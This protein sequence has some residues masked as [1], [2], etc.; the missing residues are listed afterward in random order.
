MKIFRHLLNDF[1]WTCDPSCCVP[2]SIPTRPRQWFREEIAYSVIPV[3]SHSRLQVTPLQSTPGQRVAHVVG[4][5]T[6]VQERFD[7]LLP[8]P[9]PS[10]AEKRNATPE[11]NCT[12]PHRSRSMPL[13]CFCLE[14]LSCITVAV[15]LLKLWPMSHETNFLPTCT[16][17]GRAH[18][19]TWKTLDVPNRALRRALA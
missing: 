11:T 9:L 19:P 4:Q 3:A 12:K 6:R 1:L 15:F 16:H 5:H 8:F 13:F 14:L 2:V 17:S 7:G 10:T 18:G